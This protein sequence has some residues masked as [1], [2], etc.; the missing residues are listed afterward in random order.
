MENVP[1]G[2]EVMVYIFF[3][4]I[5]LSHRGMGDRVMN[6]QRFQSHDITVPR[7]RQIR[8]ARSSAPAADR[9]RSETPGM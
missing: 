2:R 8:K 4:C 1:E 9:R 5:P 6:R 3:S 7:A